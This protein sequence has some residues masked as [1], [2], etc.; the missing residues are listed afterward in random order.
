MSEPL[1]RVGTPEEVAAMHALMYELAE[2]E[3]LTHFVR[4]NQGKRARCAV[5]HASFR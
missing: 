5:R 3:K 2:F 4:P 1:I